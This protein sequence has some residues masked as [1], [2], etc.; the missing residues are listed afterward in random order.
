MLGST[1]A[2]TIAHSIDTHGWAGISLPGYTNLVLRRARPI[3]RMRI[4]QREKS[5]HKNT[6]KSRP[7]KARN[8]EKLREITRDKILFIMI[9]KAGNQQVRVGNHR[10]PENSYSEESQCVS[11]VYIADCSDQ[12]MTDEDFSSEH[13]EQGM[14]VESLYM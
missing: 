11:I 14:W 4:R 6:K 3:F 1:I 5:P 7:S 13:S 12:A 2:T 9:T 10:N 8:R